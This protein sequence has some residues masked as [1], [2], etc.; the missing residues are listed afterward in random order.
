MNDKAV[1]CH[2]AQEC[3]GLVGIFSVKLILLH[4]Q[5]WEESQDRNI[6][7]W[8]WYSGNIVFKAL[9]GNLL[10]FDAQQSYSFAF[11]LQ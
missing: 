3:F 2:S 4:A 8:R 5:G 9:P 10:S 6:L 1:L 11:E 7:I